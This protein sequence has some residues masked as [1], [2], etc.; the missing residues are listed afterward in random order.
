[1]SEFNSKKRL[2]RVGKVLEILPI[3]RSTFL[4]GVS[5]GRYPQPV[6]LGPNIVAWREIDIDKIV[7]NGVNN[8]G[9]FE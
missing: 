7:E 5:S 4:A 1:M 8:Y 9:G 3:G 2:L 6:R